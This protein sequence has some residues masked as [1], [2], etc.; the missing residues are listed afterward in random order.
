MLMTQLRST[1]QPTF[2]S[3]TVTCQPRPAG[4]DPDTARSL[5][6]ENVAACPER[7]KLGP[8]PHS[9]GCR[10]GLCGKLGDILYCCRLNLHLCVC[11]CVSL[12]VSV[13]VC[14]AFSFVRY[15]PSTRKHISSPCHR[16]CKTIIDPETKNLSSPFNT[17][18]LVSVICRTGLVTHPR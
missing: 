9:L 6:E 18:A 5:T 10:H 4:A 8:T 16:V 14:L 11:V 17:I 7:V 12:S 15:R 3:V 2:S 13:S 1:Q